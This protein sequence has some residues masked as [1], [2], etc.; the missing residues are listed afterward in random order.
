MLASTLIRRALRLIN[1]PGRGALLSS[2]DQDAAFETLQDLLN[3]ESISKQFQPGIRRH[4]FQLPTDTDMYTYGPGGDL[5]TNMF[6]D[7]TP[8]RIEDAYIRLGS[9]IVDNEL[10]VQDLFNSAIGWT[11]GAGWAV[12]NGQGIASASSAALSQVLTTTIGETY[13][14][15]LQDVDVTAGSL[16]LS[17]DGLVQVLNSSG[18]YEFQYT[19]TVVNPLLELTGAAFTGSLEQVSVR[20][21]TKSERTELIGRGSDY[22]VEVVDQKH[23][24]NRFSKGT[25]G[26]PY[27]ILFSRAWPLAELRFDN[28]PS[29]GDKLV[30]D[31]TVNRIGLEQVTDQI[32]MHDDAIR[33]L[34]YQLAYE[35]APE[36]GKTLSPSA[37]RVLN[38]SR[39]QL[40]AG[41]A[42]LNNLRVD[43]A[44]RN[45]RSFDVNRG[46]P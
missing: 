30:M 12:Q 39:R 6:E 20:D 44:L 38:R 4:F 10:V 1:V 34:R 13:R 16:T 35:M 15:K 21:V 31:V 32:R 45:R 46:D 18:D 8:V 33:F 41:N 37:I 42:R 40:Q 5:D 24:N 25:G 9:T 11:I 2:A 29:A 7:P 43:G 17:I 26:R 23:Y 22:K 36:Y 19:A 28:A 3:G 27:E 14:V